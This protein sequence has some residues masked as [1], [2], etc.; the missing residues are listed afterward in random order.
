VWKCPFK[1]L[2]Q[3]EVGTAQV[4]SG[5]PFYWYSV[6]IVG[7]MGSFNVGISNPVSN[8]L[9][10]LTQFLRYPSSGTWQNPGFEK[11]AASSSSSSFLECCFHIMDRPVE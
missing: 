7:Y 8:N 11:R 4:S 6:T 1:V 3:F 10:S 5:T 2:H 9:K